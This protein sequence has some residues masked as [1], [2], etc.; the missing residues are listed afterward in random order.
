MKNLLKNPIFLS[1]KRY[2][3]NEFITVN[4]ITAFSISDID[5]EKEFSFDQQLVTEVLNN[6]PNLNDLEY[7]SV[8]FGFY[9]LIHSNNE[10]PSLIL[11]IRELFSWGFFLLQFPNNEFNFINRCILLIKIINETTIEKKEIFSLGQVSIGYFL[12]KLNNKLKNITLE[13]E[14]NN[15]LIEL[16]ILC[17]KLFEKSI[18]LSDNSLIFFLEFY[19][20]LLF[21]YHL[22]KNYNGI[23]LKLFSDS[24]RL[25]SEALIKPIIL[26]YNFTLLIHHLFSLISENS[27][28]IYEIQILIFILISKIPNKYIPSLNYI[29]DKENIF[30][31]IKF[32]QKSFKNKLINY[33]NNFEKNLNKYNKLIIPSKNIINYNN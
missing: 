21:F 20:N 31:I 25:I 26:N 1:Q 30:T 23:L 4:C 33:N 19:M 9:D 13:I 29:F 15:D 32:I 28:I 22:N 12:Y 27:L 7:L 3:N 18:S 8:L 11:S 16:I 10:K 2:P 17:L 6:N 24:I 5:S 14:E